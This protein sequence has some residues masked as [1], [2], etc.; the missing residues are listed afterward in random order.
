M[1][2]PLREAMKGAIAA[3]IRNFREDDTREPD[4][5]ESM[6]TEL[7]AAMREGPAFEAMVERAAGEYHDDVIGEDDPTWAELSSGL[8][9]GL[10]CPMRKAI[11]AALTEGDTNG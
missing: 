9:N 5:Y 10:C 8:R 1:A 11:I 6:V 4:G 2:D 3:N 7:L